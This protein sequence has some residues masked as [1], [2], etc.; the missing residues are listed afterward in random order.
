MP[1]NTLIHTTTPMKLKFKKFSNCDDDYH[2]DI[3]RIVRIFA[4]RGYG[5]SYCDARTAWE[6]Y[7]D[8]MC[9]GW[10]NLGEEDDYVF[11]N[12]SHYFEE[13]SDT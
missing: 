4:D 11:H 3:N 8:S 1:Y 7:S 13:E 2:Y 10:M 6:K 9:A 12:V 5:I